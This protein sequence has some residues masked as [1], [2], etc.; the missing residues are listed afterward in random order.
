ELADSYEL[1]N[2]IDK[3]TIDNLKERLQKEVDENVDEFTKK[4][5]SIINEYNAIQNVIDSRKKN[6]NF[7]AWL[8]RRSENYLKAQ[9]YKQLENAYIDIYHIVMS[10]L[11]LLPAMLNPL[12]TDLVVNQVEDKK[13]NEKSI[14]DLESGTV[15]DAPNTEVFQMKSRGD[16]KSS[17]ENIGALANAQ[18]TIDVC[19][20]AN[21]SLG[22]KKE[23]GYTRPIVF[24]DNNGKIIEED[25]TD[26]NRFVTPIVNTSENLGYEFNPMTFVIPGT[27]KVF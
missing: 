13:Y 19:Q 10:D 2:F 27:E 12:T 5:E 20:T 14:S 22:A 16:N 4:F 1:S 23:D 25:D 15:I 21:L 24:K 3:K 9:K 11:D 6:F 7:E 18:S 26:K 8:S 17:K